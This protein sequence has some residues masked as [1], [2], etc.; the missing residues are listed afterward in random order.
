MEEK[1]NLCNKLVNQ[2]R[3]KLELIVE[4]AADFETKCLDRQDEF[5]S[6]LKENNECTK[7]MKHY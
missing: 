7:N 2:P 3:E 4:N 6:A 1:Q 5:I